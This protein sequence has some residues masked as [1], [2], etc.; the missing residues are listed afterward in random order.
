MWCLNS[1]DGYVIHF[2]IYQGK[3]PNGKPNFENIFGKCMAPLMYF[4]ENVP[5]EKRKLHFRVFYDNLFTSYNL[6]SF[7]RDRGY[8][9]T[10]TI[11][12]NRLGKDF[13]LI[14]KK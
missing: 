13:P 6:L 8:S 5:P 11:K 7:L 10:G 14:G 12:E 2:A 3:F 1:A 9:R 4:L